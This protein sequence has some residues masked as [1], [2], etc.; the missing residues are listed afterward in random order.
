M[1]KIILLAYEND[2]KFL[3]R[4]HDEL[5]SVGHE[6]LIV[7]S[8]IS[9]A[10]KLSPIYS[11]HFIGIASALERFKETMKTNIDKNR[12]YLELADIEKSLM[13]RR[14]TFRQLLRTT[15]YLYEDHH[16]RKPYYNVPQDSIRA[17]FSLEVTRWFINIIDSF[18]PDLVFCLQGNYF[19][20]QLAASISQKKGYLFRALGVS[21]V[22]EYMILLDEEF[23]PAFDVKPS[24]N[25]LD[26]ARIIL[27]EARISPSSL[28]YKG[29]FN[30]RQ[31][32]AKRAGRI[33]FAFQEL[34]SFFPRFIISLR[35]RVISF[36]RRRL[37]KSKVSMYWFNSS[38]VKTTLF[39]LT[40]SCKSFFVYLFYHKIFSSLSDLKYLKKTG[41]RFVVYP[42]H[43]LPESNTLSFS[44][45]YYEL[46]HIRHISSR[47]SV[48]SF[49]L[50]KENIQMIGYRK[51]NF[52]RS[53]MKLGNVRLV[54]PSISPDETF[55]LADSYIGISGTSLLEALAGGCA[56]VSA[57]GS[58]EFKSLIGSEYLGYSGV[59]KM[60]SDFNQCHKVSISPSALEQYFANL[61]EL[62]IKFDHDC[63]NHAFHGFSC[64]S[65]SLVKMTA[66]VVSCIDKCLE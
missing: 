65:Q 54:D 18:K 56:H 33:S 23:M 58:P 46:D 39:Q 45:N 37:F 47:L 19:V 66:S 20:K 60:I 52:Y 59:E 13:S 14:K 3:C 42:L 1:K 17:I 22:R 10:T 62:N 57:Y 40:S 26:M 50:V 36:L 2:S 24:N 51:W 61:V 4:L 41:L 55:K 49:L 11:K 64:D 34:F 53:I 25:S 9:T 21:R 29:W 6:V 31:T 16:T 27:S 44:E 8:S 30:L 43:V 63:L 15:P 38:F 7:E 5:T 35:I 32:Q 28:S 48:D 12:V